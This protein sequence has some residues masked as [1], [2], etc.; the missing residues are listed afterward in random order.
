MTWLLV[1]ISLKTMTMAT[2][3]FPSLY[4]CNAIA[5]QFQARGFTAQCVVKEERS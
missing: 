3:E 4:T 5:A 1:V 2:H